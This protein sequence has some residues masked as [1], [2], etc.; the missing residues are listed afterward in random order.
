MHKQKGVALIVVMSL[1]AIS[2]MIGLMSMQS[3]Q[4]DERLAGNYKA[5]AEAQMH[6]EEAAS[7]LYNIIG[8]KTLWV[9]FEDEE[10]GED[11]AWD[12][13][14]KIFDEDHC[15][16]VEHDHGEGI[17]CYV[18]ISDDYAWDLGLSGDGDYIIAMGAVEDALSQSEPI[19]VELGEGGLPPEIRDPLENL[20]LGL[21]NVMRD[22]NFSSSQNHQARAW[23]EQVVINGEVFSSADDV[24]VFR[25]YLF[26]LSESEGNVTV[27]GPNPSAS[28]FNSGSG[29]ILVIDG[30]GFSIPNNID[31][32][33]VLVVFG[34]D[35]LLT[36]GGNI[37][38][39]GAILHVPYFCGD[40]GCE[41]LE[42]SIDIRGGNGNFDYS[43]VEMVIS[44]FG[45]NGEGP[46]T[47]R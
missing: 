32:E 22:F 14:K 31:F 16:R 41:Y 2:L 17:A 39:N 10:L 29:G 27:L 7:A 21:Y 26:L 46:I 23:E 1:L 43:V 19:F 28:E 15:E 13:F 20:S 8:E 4:V 47:W 3:S 30:D 12:D 36:G 33:G 5:A 11:F 40:E 37:D 44:S 18:E 9:N 42:P 6:A 24:V 34:E 35:F 38:F 45:G 25:D